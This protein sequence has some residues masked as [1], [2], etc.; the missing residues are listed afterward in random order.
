[1]TLMAPKKTVLNFYEKQVN[2]YLAKLR[3]GN[4]ELITDEN[5]NQW[6][7]TN[8]MPEDKGA[9][10]A[11]QTAENFVEDPKKYSGDYV[12]DYV[13]EMEKDKANLSEE[14]LAEYDDDFQLDNHLR[15]IITNQEF[16][17]KPL[18]IKDLIASDP[19]LR[20]YVEG[21]EQRY[22]EGADGLDNPIVVGNWDTSYGV[23]D[24]YNRILTKYNNGDEFIEAYVSE[25]NI[26]Y[27]EAM[28]PSKRADLEF[29]R[30]DANEKRIVEEV[31]AE[32]DIVGAR[33]T[34]LSYSDEEMET[35]Y[36]N[37]VKLAKRRKWVLDAD[38]ASLKSRLTGIDVDSLI[39]SHTAEYEKKKPI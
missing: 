25:P 12:A 9:V 21:N 3:K 5:Y 20:A 29:R 33:E 11:F 14:E 2:R 39:F 31:A 38:E 37:F 30:Q 18:R 35:G 16:I 27:Q 10:E 34:D 4:W 26:K 28:E 7:E 17:L 24:G 15:N 23:L 22:P 36:Q 6:Y 1:M 8:I 32:L 19:D 13:N